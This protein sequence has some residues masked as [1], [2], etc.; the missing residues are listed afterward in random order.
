MGLDMFLYK[1]R[2]IDS[3]A[4]KTLKI[5]GLGSKKMNGSTGIDINKVSYIEFEVG[6]WRKFNALH[7][8]FVTN[9]QKGVDECQ[10]SDVST[11]D[12]KK[13]LDILNKI[14][15][16]K[17]KAERVKIAKMLLPSTDG[18]FFG[19]TDYDVYYFNSV[20]ETKELIEQEL[21]DNEGIFDEY[22]Y[23]ASW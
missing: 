18:F 8:W 3:E 5:T 12:L 11:D 14:L 21:K 9:V 2:Y 20:K 17:T 6:Y 1:K 7:K 16:G 15:G 10:A 19:G 23:R 13:L 22:Y 4:K